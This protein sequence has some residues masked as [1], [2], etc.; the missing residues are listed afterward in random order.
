MIEVVILNL[1]TNQ[2]F[3][4]VFDSPYLYRKFANKCKHSKK[5]KI[6]SETYF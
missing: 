6:I 4:K 1:E 5:V 2:T 3:K